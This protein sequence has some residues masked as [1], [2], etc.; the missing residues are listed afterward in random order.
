MCIP[1]LMVIIVTTMF[2]GWAM[3]NQQGVKAASRYAAWRHVYTSRYEP[4]YRPDD[5]NNIYDADHPYLDAHV[6]RGEGSNIN[7][8][9]GSGPTDEFEELAD[10]AGQYSGDA[11]D[12]ASELLIH[13]TYYHGFQR[14]RRAEVSSDFT[15]EV[16]AFRRFQ[17]SIHS[18]HIR[19][20]VEWR[21]HQAELR[22]A[23]REQFL[24]PLHDALESVPSPGDGMARMIEGLYKHGW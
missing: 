24:L 12:L 4:G 21:R 13:R 19:D 3:M 18:H 9:G 23:I 22:R 7:I 10:T 17:G 5:P 16:E 20:G 14:A 2:F 15:S 11:G 1:L 6:L 8:D